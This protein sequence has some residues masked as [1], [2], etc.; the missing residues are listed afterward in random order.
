MGGPS[1]YDNQ[2]GQISQLWVSEHWIRMLLIQCRYTKK[3][4]SIPVL[5]P[6]KAKKHQETRS[7]L[8]SNQRVKSQSLQCWVDCRKHVGRDETG[9]LQGHAEQWGLICG[10]SGEASWCVGSGFTSAKGRFI[11]TQSQQREEE[12]E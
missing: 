3:T 7:W 11:R 6:P 10:G 4:L 5:G 1:L 8:D 12:P 2:Q 9:S